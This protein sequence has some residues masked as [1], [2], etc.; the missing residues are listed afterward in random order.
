MFLLSKIALN[1]TVV[2]AGAIG[3]LWASYLANA[4]HN[5]SLW[6]R[7][8]KNQS[9]SLALDNAEPKHF[10]TNSESE[11]R[12]SDLLLVTV[13]A[14]Q[15]HDA[16]AP[17]LSRIDPRTVILFLHNG[18]GTV[19]DLPDKVRQHP[20]VLATT[21]HGAYKPSITVVQHTGSGSTILGGYNEL[22]KKCQFL[23]GVFAHAL[24]KTHWEE[25]IENALWRKLAINCVINPLTAIK[26]CRN[27]ELLKAQYSGIIK[28]LVDEI[29]AVMI[30]ENLHIENTALLKSVNEVMQ[31]TAKNHSSMKQDIALQRRT[32]IDYITGY[33]CK[34]A[35][36]HQIAVP[37]NLDLFQQIKKLEKSWS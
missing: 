13:K 32:E 27:G 12:K 14:W 21:T 37:Q 2:G 34:V 16:I 7:T 36:Q 5:I 18:M 15:V 9:Y 10:S 1:I 20:I 8:P 26:Q 30:A 23:A 19:D 4:G 6:T 35:E 22:G 24:P 28:R 17:L 25:S 11:L 31:A 33:L 29:C 3:S